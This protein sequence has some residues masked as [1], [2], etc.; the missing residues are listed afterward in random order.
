VKRAKSEAR[1]ATLTSTEQYQALVKEIAAQ[2]E[3]IDAL[4]SSILEAME[5][6]EEMR[7]QR[8]AEK[9]RTAQALVVL[10]AQQAQLR[11]DL[12]AAQ[13]NV[14]KESAGR[15]AAAAAVDPTTRT[16]Y[17]RIL[18]AKRDAALALVNGQVC[19]ICK[20]VQPP[21]V[22]QMLR[23]SK[24]TQTCQMCGRILVWDPESQ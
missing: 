21:Q 18:G 19:G 10:D 6:S 13:A 24:G 3:R 8:D 16:L 12:S 1:L 9:A 17:E 5:R 2:L 14:P 4:E 23:Q 20:A 11:A 15:D 7:Q 22:V